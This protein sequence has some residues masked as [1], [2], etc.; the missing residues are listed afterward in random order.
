MNAVPG[1]KVAFLMPNLKTGGT[2]RTMSQLAT[3]FSKHGL[4]VDFILVK[5][6]GSFIGQLPPQITVIDLNLSSTYLSLIPVTRYLRHAHPQV[7]IAALDLT[8]LVAI[9]SRGSSGVDTRLVIRLVSTI[10]L[11]KRSPVMKRL[12]KTL[13]AKLYPRADDIIAV[14][15]SVAEDFSIYTGIPTE[16]VQTIYNPIILPEFEALSQEPLNHEWFKSDQPPVVLAAG[17][18]VY[19]KNF[20]C[21]IRAFHEVLR[22]VEARLIILGEGEE[23]TVLKKLVRDL[24][25]EPWVSLPGNVANPYSYMSRAAVFVLSSRY[26]GLPNVLVEAM[27]CGCP[28]IS[29]NS[30][31][32]AAE[33]LNFGEYGHLVPS[34]DSQALAIA[35]L[36][37]LHGNGKKVPPGWLQQFELDT[38]VIQYLQLLNLQ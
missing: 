35:I 29:T 36:D 7:M 38:V 14:S 8:N 2:E 18:L 17:R 32:G 28:V 10:S 1:R 37:V 19:A 30:P 6:Q 34:G 22:A 16:R 9:L 3:G 23:R 31:G 13:L 20:D 25:I 26:E 27:A 5:A 33:I 4:Q 24:H 12:E 21:L 15:H 11:Q